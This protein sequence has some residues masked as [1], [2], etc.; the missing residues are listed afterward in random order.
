[1]QTTNPPSGGTDIIITPRLTIPL[2]ELAFQFSRSGGKGGQNVNKLETKVEL[3]FDVARSPALD[4]A[5]RARLFAKLATRL[6]S[7]GTL[8]LMSQT[9]RSQ[10]QNKSDVT[11]RFK[12]LL[13]Q[14]LIVEK[15]R[16]ATKPTRSAKEK[17][18]T[19]KRQQSV[20]KAA[21][22]TATDRSDD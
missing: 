10:L 11:D 7:G 9:Y 5:S 17:R 22:R 6:D 14:A 13:Q 21:R 18:L 8:R 15:P 4:E 16:T 12:L 20:R 2:S 1:M 3:F 19:S